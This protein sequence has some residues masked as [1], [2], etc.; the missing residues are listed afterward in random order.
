MVFSLVLAAHGTNVDGLWL[1]PNVPRQLKMGSILRF[2]G[3]TRSYEVRVAQHRQS[4][5]T[6]CRTGAGQ[7]LCP[8]HLSAAHTMLQGD[9][10]CICA[11]AL[12]VKALPSA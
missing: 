10:D 12:Q 7:R 11:L 1:R 9:I 6:C 5:A 4:L 8:L 2:G 3:S